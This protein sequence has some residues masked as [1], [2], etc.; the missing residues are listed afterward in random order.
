MTMTNEWLSKVLFSNELSICIFFPGH[1]L[2][3][4]ILL[5]LLSYCFLLPCHV[6]WHAVY[7]YWMHW[8]FLGKKHFAQCYEH[9]ETQNI[10]ENCFI[11]WVCFLGCQP[12]VY[13]AGD[14]DVG[15]AGQDAEPAWGFYRWDRRPRRRSHPGKCFLCSLC[16]PAYIFPGSARSKPTFYNLPWFETS[17]VKGLVL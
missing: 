1:S 11:F 12:S 3:Q 13:R 7:S 15:L 17:Q 5:C 9:M 6:G 14:S 10:W 16:F 4:P 8:I 2:A